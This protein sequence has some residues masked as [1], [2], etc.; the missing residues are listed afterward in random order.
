MKSY[1]HIKKN[2]DP[3]HKQYP[4]KIYVKIETVEAQSIT[5]RILYIPH[6]LTPSKFFFEGLGGSDFHNLND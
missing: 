3:K 6:F 1:S 2:W 5:N 4:K